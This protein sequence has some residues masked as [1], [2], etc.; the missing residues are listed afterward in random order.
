MLHIPSCSH[1][2]LCLGAEVVLQAGQLLVEECL[3]AR[4]GLLA[5]TDVVLQHLAHRR[6]SRLPRFLHVDSIHTVSMCVCVYVRN[7][8][9]YVVL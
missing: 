9:A 6:V 2:Y 3:E 7:V 1:H 5:Q 8:S 4:L